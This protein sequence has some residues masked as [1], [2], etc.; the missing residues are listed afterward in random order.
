MDIFDLSGKK[1]NLSIC[2]ENIKIMEYIGDVKEL[3][4]QEAINFANQGI[5]VFNPKNKFFNDLCYYYD[6]KD[7]KDIIIDDRRK[8]IYQNA[9]FCQDGCVY[10]GMDSVL[11]TANC[12][13]DINFLQYKDS[14]NIKKEE[15]IQVDKINF[16]SITKSF[17]SNLYDF[18]F[19]VMKC[20]NLILNIKVLK[21]NMG[22]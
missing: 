18:N 3:D 15:K 7:K 19:E 22:F 14:N 2:Q 6:N 1:L 4:I 11:M 20:Y 13:C 12:F 8:D 21:I 9:T 16:D 17:I 5:D 10:D